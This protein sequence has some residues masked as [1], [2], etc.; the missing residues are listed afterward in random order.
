M[1]ADQDG[2]V[3]QVCGLE[4]EVILL[5]TWWLP[6]VILGMRARL[7]CLKSEGPGSSGH[8]HGHAYGHNQHNGQGPVKAALAQLRV[9]LRQLSNYV[10]IG[11]IDE[12]D[13]L[14]VIDYAENSRDV[15]LGD[16]DDLECY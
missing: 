3:D 15:L 7:A 5:D 6:K 13:A 1:D 10:R 16:Y 14:A 8:G 4:E 2:C 11:W 9:F 12:K